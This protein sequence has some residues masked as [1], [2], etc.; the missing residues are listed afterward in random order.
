[1]AVRFQTKRLRCQ[2]ACGKRTVARA[3]CLLQHWVVPTQTRPSFSLPLRPHAISMG[4]VLAG[5]QPARTRLQPQA[6][7]AGNEEM[8]PV[9][10]QL[11]ALSE[12][13]PSQLTVRHVPPYDAD[14]PRQFAPAHVPFERLAEWAIL[15]D[16]PGGGWSG[17]LKFLPLLQRPLIVLDRAAWGWADG[18]LLEPY[19]HYRPVRQ[20]VEKG[21]GPL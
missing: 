17:R 13:A 8:H 10:A 3:R 14:G 7:F 16:A 11:R 19:V 6:F 21:A 15:L 1:M 12:R 5:Q 20:Q 9:R 18:A 2:T 4:L